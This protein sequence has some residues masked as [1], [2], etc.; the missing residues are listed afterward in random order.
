VGGRDGVGGG[1]RAAEGVVPVVALQAAVG[2]EL[3]NPIK[4]KLEQALPV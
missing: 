1:V 4:K 3:Q 2:V